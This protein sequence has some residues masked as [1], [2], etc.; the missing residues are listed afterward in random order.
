MNSATNEKFARIAQR[1][2]PKSRLVRAWALQG[3]VSAQVTALEIE[4][5]DGKRQ[6]LIV[7]RHGVADLSANPH[8]AA[9]EFR[10][11]KRLY[12]ADLPV[13]TPYMVDASGDIFDTP[14]IV[15]EYVEG[16]TEFAPDDLNE[17]LR[18]MAQT[19]ARIHLLD[20]VTQDLAFLPQEAERTAKLLRERPAR[21]DESLGEGRIRD[22]LEAAGWRETRNP[23]V[24]LHGDYWSGNVLWKDGR[25][26]A[27]IDWEDAQLGDPLAD[28]ANA[29]L[30]ILWAFGDEAMRAFTKAYREM[31]SFDLSDLPYRDLIAALK[32]AFK[33]AEWA[34]D[35]NAEHDMR[36]KHKLFVEQ[37]LAQLASK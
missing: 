19:L 11:L 7:R 18:Q 35:E 28:V 17:H 5:A 34:A 37:A 25:L 33:L 10:L 36:E 4:R 3:G 27:I 2:E 32:P 14:Y 21:M 6:K 1:A 22:A 31:T 29:R 23:V 30:E 12:I 15:V 26:A 16:A 13:P 20:G 9:D 24:L 8:I